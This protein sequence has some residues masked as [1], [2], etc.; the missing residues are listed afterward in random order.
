MSDLV[1]ISFEEALQELEGIVSTLEAG[2]ISLDK[3][4][5]SYERGV[6][7]QK[8]CKK[9]LDEAKMRVEKIVVNQEG[10]ASTVPL[11]DT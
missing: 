9:K 6:I 10:V 4:I 5:T 2:N 8:H 11:E 7:L 1:D 3:A